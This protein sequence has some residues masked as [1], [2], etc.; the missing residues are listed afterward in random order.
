MKE[1][2]KK[3]THTINDSINIPVT[4]ENQQTYNLYIVYYINC[5]VNNNYFDWLFNQIKLVYHFNGTIYVVATINRNEEDNFRK[6]LLK[7]YP[8]I[9]IEFYYDNEYEYRGILKIWEL[10]QI[11]NTPNDILLYFHSKGLTYHKQYESNKNDCCNIILH[12]ID[13]VKEIFDIFPSID[14]V[15]YYSGGCGWI[16]YNFWYARGSYI[17]KVEKPIKTERRHYY[18][19]W[20]GRKVKNIDDIVCETQERPF[21]FYENTLLSCYGLHSNHLFGNI[22]SGY[23]PNRNEMFYIL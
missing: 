20:L 12:N 14:K 2:T 4:L 3:Y 9:I 18:E 15:G 8:N 6:K 10:G 13:K 23:C 5:L 11:H 7:M 16:W 1:V 21:S 17:S 19:D 22:G